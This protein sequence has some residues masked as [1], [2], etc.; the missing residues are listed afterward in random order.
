[1]WSHNDSGAAVLF[2]IDGSGVRGRVQ[3]ANASVDDWEDITAAPCP[4]GNCLYIADIGDNKR[5]RRNITIYR[6]PEP[7]ADEAQTG[8]AERF[9]LTY[10]DGPHDA[11]ALFIVDAGLF[12]I[13][14]DDTGALYRI[15]QLPRAG[16]AATFERVGA[17]LLPRVTDADASPDGNL[18]AV[19]TNDELVLYRTADLVRGGSKT[20]GVHIPLKA[21]KEPQGEGVAVGADGRVYLA[22]EASGSAGRL[23][24]LR[25]T[26][27]Q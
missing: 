11:E 17:L 26:L 13:T 4:S 24:S 2:A 23:T 14:K 1:M 25:C 27:P 21:L 20:T 7:A 16:G 9:T 18:V 6:V 3:V 8:T 5:A 12:V 22:S 15:P 10:P 19:R